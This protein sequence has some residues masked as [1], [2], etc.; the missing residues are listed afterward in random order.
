MPRHERPVVECILGIVSDVCAKQTVSCAEARLIRF[1]KTLADSVFSA[2]VIQRY[3]KY[4]VTSPHRSNRKLF[5]ILPIL[6]RPYCI[7][8]MKLC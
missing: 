5:M 8:V 7:V 2:T 6:S 3:T 4:H 1:L